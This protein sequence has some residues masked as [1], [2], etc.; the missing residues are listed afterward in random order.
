MLSLKKTP[1]CLCCRLTIHSPVCFWL[2]STEGILYLLL[3]TLPRTRC[4]RG[5][6][7][8][9]IDSYRSIVELINSR[10]QCII[11]SNMCFWLNCYSL[12]KCYSVYLKEWRL[13]EFWISEKKK[14]KEFCIISM[15]SLFFNSVAV[16][17]W[18]LS[19]FDV[20][21]LCIYQVYWFGVDSIQLIEF[22]IID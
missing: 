10:Y 6:T 12:S 16:F 17:Y 5:F 3:Y 18:F 4:E 2:W 15:E 7:D 22:L 1:I 8:C 20:E 14:L 19:I 13:I 21:S 9:I 11:Y